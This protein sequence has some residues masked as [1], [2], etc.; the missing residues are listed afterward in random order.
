MYNSVGRGYLN[1]YSFAHNYNGVVNL[2][3]HILKSSCAKLLAAKF[4]LRT[5]KKVFEKFGSDMSV[6]SDVSKNKS[7]KRYSFLPAEYGVSNKFQ[8]KKQPSEVINSLYGTKSLSTLENLTC[9]KCGSNYR[10]EM[11]HIRALKDLNP[12]VSHFDRLMIRAKRKQL[13]LCR[14]CHMELH[15]R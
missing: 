2:V 4:N 5:Q 9:S 3:Q 1:Y 10:V 12:K 11:H 13:A 6:T 8:L 7:N 14:E 15:N